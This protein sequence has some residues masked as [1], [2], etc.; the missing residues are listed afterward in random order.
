MKNTKIGIA[1]LLI[2]LSVMLGGLRALH[3]FT[4]SAY[5]PD[6]VMNTPE[7]TTV[8]LLGISLVGLTCV[9]VVRKMKKQRS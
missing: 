7:P 6:P 3:A 9:G 8:M 1:I 5:N 2:C 4:I